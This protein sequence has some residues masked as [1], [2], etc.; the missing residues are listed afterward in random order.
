MKTLLFIILFK[1]LISNSFAISRSEQHQKIKKLEGE[2]SLKIG[3]KFACSDFLTLDECIT[4]LEEAK[5]ELNVD[6]SSYNL[7][8]I[9]VMDEVNSPSIN[10]RGS[11]FIEFGKNLSS[12]I[13]LLLNQAKRIPELEE[14]VLNYSITQKIIIECSSI[15]KV[16]EC[17]KTFAKVKKLDFSEVDNSFFKRLVLTD[18]DS[19]LNERGVI[20]VS[21][22]NPDILGYVL[23][24]F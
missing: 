21:Y 19:P 15:T 13:S 3:T 17:E 9:T 14:Q 5:K 6:L 18:F 1:L 4:T 12:Q 2:I 23:E 24:Q 11:L 16:W 22:E 20:Y 7:N 10:M 8:R